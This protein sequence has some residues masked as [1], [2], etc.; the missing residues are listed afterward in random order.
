MMIVPTY[1]MKRDLKLRTIKNISGFKKIQMKFS[2]R[3]IVSTA[4]S[5]YN[6]K[7]WNIGNA[8]RTVPWGWCE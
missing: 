1:Q 4:P 6:K 3:K 5:I 2:K 7:L 8:I